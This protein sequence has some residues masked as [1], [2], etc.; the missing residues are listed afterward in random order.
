[1]NNVNIE[2]TDDQGNVLEKVYCDDPKA[3]TKSI[4]YDE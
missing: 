4:V 3:A 1:M 2:I